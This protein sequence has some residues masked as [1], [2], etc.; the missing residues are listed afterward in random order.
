MQDDHD[1]LPNNR[2][3]LD[4]SEEQQ[5]RNSNPTSFS[6]RADD[7]QRPPVVSGLRDTSAA[8]TQPYYAQ[9]VPPPPPPEQRESAVRERVRRR[10]VSSRSRGGE[11]AWVVIALTMLSVVVIISMSVFVLLRASQ[12]KEEIVPTAAVVLP[13]PVEVANGVNGQRGSADGQ[14]FTL[15]DG[16]SITLA[17]WNGTSRFTVLVVGLDRRPGETGLAYRTDTMMLVSLDPQSKS[18]GILSIPRDLYVEVPGYSELQRV[19]SPMVLGELQQPGY[20]PELMK[21]TVQNNLGIRI[22]DYV[23]VD[24][25]T[26][27]TIVDAIGGVDIDVPYNISDP[28]YPDMNY[29]YD[30][31]YI[32]AGLHHL[33]GITAL[34]YART[35]HGDNDFQ[36]ADRQQQVLY[37]I[38]DRVLNLNMLPQLIV[39][40]PTIWK[41]VSDGVSTGLSLDQILQLGWYLKDIPGSNIHTGVIDERYTTGYSTPRGESVLV[42]DRARLG[43][44]MVQVF[45]ANYSE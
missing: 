35:R 24:F 37:A 42:P 43:E 5:T 41:A 16:R 45:G 12:A 44:L 30:P 34:K 9:A 31:F 17:P 27:I 19:N 8:V 32:K 2:P 14:Q 28:E 13:T 40:A 3:I 4:F 36:R 10:R 39:Q 26:F 6:V 23:A 7:T 29:G 18:L 25:N 38:R 33:D 1:T 20:G 11:W 15:D 22:H 21:Q